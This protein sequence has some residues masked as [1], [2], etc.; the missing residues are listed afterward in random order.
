[1]LVEKNYAPKNSPDLV[2]LRFADK[3][4][5]IPNWADDGDVAVDIL[6]K[7]WLVGENITSHEPRIVAVTLSTKTPDAIVAI[8]GRDSWESDYKIFKEVFEFKRK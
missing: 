1:M 6:V 2:V 7:V 8:E 4:M 5:T 3:S